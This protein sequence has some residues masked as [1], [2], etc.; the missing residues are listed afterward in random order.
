MRETPLSHCDPA[1]QQFVHFLEGHRDG[2]GWLDDHKPG[3]ALFCRALEGG[4]KARE[5]LKAMTATQWDELFEIISSDDLSRELNQ[6]HQPAWLLF[7]AVK[8][9]EKALAQLRRHKPSFAV[10]AGLIREVNEKE[11]QICNGGQPDR[12]PPSAA[13]DVG[14]LIGEMHL[15]KGEYHRAIEAFTRAIENQPSADVFEGRARAYHA[16]AAL[17]EQKSREMKRV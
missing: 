17:D 6:H 12:I 13:A 16:L 2:L 15:S 10:L 7:E 3:V 8:G 11:V 4:P 1:A 14:C 9:N 5:K